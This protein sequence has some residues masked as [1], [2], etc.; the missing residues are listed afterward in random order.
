MLLDSPPPTHTPPVSLMHSGFESHCVRGLSCFTLLRPF[1]VKAECSE[2][3][4]AGRET[5]AWGDWRSSA[6][7]MDKYGTQLDLNLALSQWA[8][9]HSLLIRW[10]PKCIRG[11]GRCIHLELKA[12]NQMF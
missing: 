9:A 2:F 10:A 3:H 1:S 4:C 12:G 7:V 6:K 8:C 5:E 11:A